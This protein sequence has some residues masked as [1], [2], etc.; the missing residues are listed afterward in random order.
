MATK[1]G[2]HIYVDVDKKNQ[3]ATDFKVTKRS[4]QSAL[5][6]Q[7]QSRLAIKIRAA[8]LNRGGVIY[9]PELRVASP[10]AQAIR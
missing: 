5:N 10:E 9:D 6:Y 4:V 2:K 7:T 3:L 8:A 1:K